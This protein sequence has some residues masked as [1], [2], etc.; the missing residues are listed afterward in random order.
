M[1]HSYDNADGFLKIPLKL[2][3]DQFVRPRRV[4]RHL[5]I[6]NGMTDHAYFK[7]QDK[8]SINVYCKAS[9]MYDIYILLCLVRFNRSSASS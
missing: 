4:T 7:I 2:Q 6:R 5:E 3:L 8:Y 9:E 1:C